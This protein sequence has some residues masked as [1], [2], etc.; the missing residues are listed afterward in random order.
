MLDRSTADRVKR[1][2]PPRNNRYYHYCSW[3]HALMRN[4]LG[5]EDAEFAFPEVVLNYIRHLVP[6]NI[7]GEIREDAFQVSLEDFCKI[8]EMGPLN[9]DENVQHV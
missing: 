4:E 6:D 5:P 8:M 3:A 1:G 9:A 2:K 7:K